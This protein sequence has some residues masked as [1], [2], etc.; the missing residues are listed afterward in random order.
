MNVRRHKGKRTHP[1]ALNSES[2]A[3]AESVDGRRRRQNNE[4]VFPPKMK[5]SDLCD[6][7]SAATVLDHFIT[8][9]DADISDISHFVC[10]V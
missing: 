8:I 3:S 10:L 4:L 7:I 2:L 1:L 6:G 9:S 5:P